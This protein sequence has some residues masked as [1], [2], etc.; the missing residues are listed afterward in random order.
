M[1]ANAGALLKF[2]EPGAELSCHAH[3]KEFE[4]NGIL[5]PR[6]VISYYAGRTLSKAKTLASWQQA[7]EVISQNDVAG[8]LITP[9]FRPVL[10]VYGDKE[11]PLFGSDEP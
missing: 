7:I 11:L 6:G 2:A 1:P 3:E 4:E 9:F 5:V 8:G 10:Q